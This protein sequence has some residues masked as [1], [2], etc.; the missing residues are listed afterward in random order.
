M[1]WSRDFTARCVRLQPAQESNADENDRVRTDQGGHFQ[2]RNQV[3]RYK[4]TLINGLNQRNMD[5]AVQ[6]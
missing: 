3:L 4:V 2:R 6:V 1:S 5:F